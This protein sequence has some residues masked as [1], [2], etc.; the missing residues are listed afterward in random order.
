MFST[1]NIKNAV[2]D[3]NTS[4]V[5]KCVIYL[6]LYSYFSNSITASF[7]WHL[8]SRYQNWKHSRE[9]RN[10]GVEIDPFKY[11]WV[12]P[13]S[14]VRVSGREDID[15]NTDVG[16]VVGGE[17]DR[18]AGQY[19]DG[20]LSISGIEKFEDHVLHQSFKRH[21]IDQ[22]PWESTE[23]INAYRESGKSDKKIDWKL[24]RHD[25]L[26][27]N[28]KTNG[29]RTKADLLG[30]DTDGLLIRLDSSTIRH[31]SN[32]DHLTR[33]GYNPVRGFR[34]IMTNEVLVDVSR[35]GELLF[36]DGKHR[37]SIAKLLNLEKIPVLILARHKK[38]IASH[39]TSEQ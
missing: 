17:W 7:Y 4:F 24:E 39:T 21:F 28:I 22:V 11:H 15:F 18:R 33:N 12:D 2:E 25:N 27:E 26:Y 13:Q 9:L 1:S 35:D 29:Y 3:E 20:P 8:D 14:I 36:V 32:T 34:D 23:L 38:W 16:L 6:S 19:G 5:R 30:I 10:N 37:L 31:G